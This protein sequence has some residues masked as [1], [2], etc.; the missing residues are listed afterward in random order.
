MVKESDLNRTPTLQLIHSKGTCSDS[1][2]LT[3]KHTPLPRSPSSA[4]SE[5]FSPGSGSRSGTRTG[6]GVKQESTQENHKRSYHLV[7]SGHAPDMLC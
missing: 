7:S 1:K 6:K 3:E 5:H 2:I 4:H